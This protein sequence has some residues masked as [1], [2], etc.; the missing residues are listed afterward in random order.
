MSVDLS[1]P[2]GSPVQSTAGERGR[3]YRPE[4]DILRFFAFLLVFI[5]H[6]FPTSPELYVAKLGFPPAVASWLVS[7]VLSGGLGVDLFFVLSA[8]LITELL[9][10]EHER[11]GRINL[12]DFYIRRALRIYP[13]YYGFLAVVIFINRVFGIAG[14]LSPRYKLMFILPLANW[15]V[16]MWGGPPSVAVHLW[17]V[18]IEEQFYLAYPLLLRFFRIRRIALIAVGMLVI[19]NITRVILVVEGAGQGAVWCNTFARLDPIAFGILTAILLKGRAIRP[20]RGARIIIGAVGLFALVAA[21]RFTQ[22]SGMTSLI[23]YPLVAG[24]ATMLLFALLR[25]QIA[26][27]RYSTRTI[28]YLGRISFGLYVW[29]ALA[30]NQ[31]HF[32]LS[33]RSSINFAANVSIAFLATVAASVASYE[34][35]ESYFLRLKERFTR[36]P[37][38]PV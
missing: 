28:I 27:K 36:V 38:R 31:V 19:A 29:H 2:A 22:G 20:G 7:F 6:A 34:L 18:G 21:A 11:F 16:A 25:M 30:L 32:K 12:R 1:T 4:L 37:S 3:F 24:G 9:V 13:L 5:N 15:A 17:S 26:G 10:R 33:E 14:Y 8:F 35:Y 23:F